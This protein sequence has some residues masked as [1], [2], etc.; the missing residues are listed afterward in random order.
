MTIA[1]ETET[2]TE[3]G[4]AHYMLGRILLTIGDVDGALAELDHAAR[5]A[6]ETLNPVMLAIALLERGDALA[7]RRQLAGAVPAALDAAARLRACVV[8]SIRWPF[9]RPRVRPPS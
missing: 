1:V 2:S 6:E 9:S 4:P 5:A 8:T 3:I 7:R